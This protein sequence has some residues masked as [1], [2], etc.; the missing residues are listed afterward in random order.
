MWKTEK[1]KRYFELWNMIKELTAERKAIGEE[2]L[3]DE[4]FES[5]VDGRMKLSKITKRKVLVK[6]GMDEEVMTKFPEA[7]KQIID[8]KVLQKDPDA[9][10]YLEI[11]ETQEIKGITLKEDQDDF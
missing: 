3:Y 9:A 6:K 10:D 11:N 4:T 7:V 2:F 8:V 5:M 1:M